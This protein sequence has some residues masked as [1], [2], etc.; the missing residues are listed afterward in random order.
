MRPIF[1]LCFA[2][3]LSMG[4][5]A[6]PSD[7][8]PADIPRKLAKFSTPRLPLTTTRSIDGSNNNKGGK[9]HARL[10]RK[11]PASYLGDRTGARLGTNATNARTISNTIANQNLSKKKNDRKMSD[12]IWA[13]GQFLE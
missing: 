6:Q 10:V 8:E 3:W 1:A 5:Y 12:M 2:S 4:A 11:G 9:A 7:A 13:W